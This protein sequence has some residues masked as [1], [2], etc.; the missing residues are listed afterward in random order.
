[1]TVESSLLE[2]NLYSVKGIAILDNDGNRIFAK[3]YNET[4]GSVKDQKTFERNLFNKTHRANGEVIMLDG[5][6]CI[7]RNSVDLFFYIMGNANENGLILNSIMNCL[8]ESLSHILK[9]N[10]E[11]KT[12]LENLDMVILALDEI[13]DGGIYLES[14]PIA[15]VQKVTANKMDDLPFNEQTVAQVLQSAREQIKWS[16]LR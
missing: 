11:K 5:F 6:T 12:L 15:I 7:Y 8:F 4:F 9:K 2:P 14:D 1:M 3:Y 16:L 10:V 13:C